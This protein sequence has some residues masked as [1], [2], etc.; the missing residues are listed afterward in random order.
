M[1]LLRLQEKARKQ[2]G[3][4]STVATRESKETTRRC[5]YCG[6]KRK[7]GNNKEMCLL[8]LQEKARKQQGDVSTVATRE[9]KET[10]RRCVYCGY[11]RK[12]GNNKEM[13]LLWLQGKARK[14]QGD[15]STV[16]TRESKETTRCVYCGYKRKQGNNKE[17]CL[18][19]LQ[20]KARKQQGDVS[21][22]ATRESKDTLLEQC[23]TR[24]DIWADRVRARLLAVNDLHAADAVYHQSCRVNCHTRKVVPQMFVRNEDPE[25]AERWETQQMHP[26]QSVMSKLKH[27]LWSLNFCK[28]TTRS[29]QLYHIWLAK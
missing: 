15:V 7:Q 27:F 16:A 28:I 20:E 18:L 14:Q 9:S 12:Q 5:V 10:T 29:K 2:Q 8:R 17:M 6:Y 11:K 22:V 19:W 21:T 25:K 23:F 1:C 26:V 24:R 13:C 3:D 4:V